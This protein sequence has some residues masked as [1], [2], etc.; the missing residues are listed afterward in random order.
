VSKGPGI[1]MR[2]VMTLLE[3]APGRRMTRKALDDTLIGEGYFA[4]NVLR[5][6]QSL[7]RRRLLFLK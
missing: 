7:S 2:R 1:L 6:I 5:S 4:Q 3:G